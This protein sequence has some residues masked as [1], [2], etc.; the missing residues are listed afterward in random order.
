M[1]RYVAQ[2]CLGC[3]GPQLAGGRIPGAPPDWPAASNLRPGADGAMQRYP[4]AVALQTMFKTGHRPD[5]TPLKVMPFEALKQLSDT[6]TQA[7]YRYL[8]SL[9]AG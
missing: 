5:G 4:S 2:M 9:P 8:K 6:D 3:H 1:A 7:L